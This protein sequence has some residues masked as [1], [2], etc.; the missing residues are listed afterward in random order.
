MTLKNTATAHGITHGRAA[1]VLS[2]GGGS[3]Y[4]VNKVPLTVVDAY[5]IRYAA[6][7]ADEAE[8]AD[9]GTYVMVL[10][11]MFDG[12]LLMGTS[13]DPMRLPGL[14]TCSRRSSPCRRPRLRPGLRQA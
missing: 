8:T 12:S 14:A 11:N 2:V 1:R 10:E 3:G 9:S 4:S 5:T 13:S 7:G 6:A